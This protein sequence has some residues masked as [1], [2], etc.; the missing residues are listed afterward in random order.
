MEPVQEAVETPAQSLEDVLSELSHDLRAPL[1]AVNLNIET[2][3]RRMPAESKTI[4]AIEP[5]LQ[6]ARE[7]VK[8]T[9]LLM[10]ELLAEARDRNL[11][12]HASLSG[13]SRVTD[14]RDL[15]HEC[16]AMHGATLHAARCAVTVRC[17]GA[18]PG[19][20]PRG[21]MFQ[22]LSNL[23]VNATKYAAGQ[24]VQIHA[25]RVGKTVILGVSDCGPGFSAEERAHV[26]DRFR[27][28]PRDGGGDGF[29]LGLWIVRRAVERLGGALRLVTAPGEGALFLIELPVVTG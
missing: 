13:G 21:A 25:T 26:F 20:W 18:I 22:I 29:G 8:Q 10:E 2:A 19:L 23:L 1:A 15:I 7:I 12:H 27:R 4:A 3:L 9:V 17:D 16:V 24:P 5:P 28:E 6:R 11:T 14:L